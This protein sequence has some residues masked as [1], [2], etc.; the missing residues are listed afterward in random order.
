M[1][2]F[3]LAL[4]FFQLGHAY[5]Y[6]KGH[7]GNKLRWN[8]SR[9]SINLY[10]NPEDQNSSGVTVE[11]VQ[12]AI[13]E[14]VED[15]NKVSPIRLNPVYTA[16][17][18]ELGSGASFRFSSNP[19]YFGKG[20]LA[21][22][23]INYDSASGSI[24]SA[25]I[26]M[27]ESL[28]SGGSFTSDKANSSGPVAYIGDVITHEVGHLLGLNHSEV[29]DSSMIYSIFKGQHSIHMDDKSAI[30]DLYGTSGS[31]GIKGKVVRRGSSPV[32][33]AHVQA[34]NLNTNEVEM[35]VFTEEDGSFELKGLSP[36]QSYALF[37]SPMKSKENLLSRFSTVQT[38]YCGGS[39]FS[40][41]FFSRCGARHIGKAQAIY[42]TNSTMVDVGL[43][44]VK[45][46]TPAIPE[47]LVQKLDDTAP[48]T[49]IHTYFDEGK[50]HM[51]FTG[52]F[53][54]TEIKEG[55]NP[56]KL[57]L[58]YSGLDASSWGQLYL[59]L[60]VSTMK[61]GSG[62]G[63][64]LQSKRSDELGFSSYSPL[65]DPIT[66]KLI[67]DFEVIRP[68]SLTNSNNVFELN[69][70]PKE[71]SSSE[72]TEIFASTATLLND[73]AIYF[74]TATIVDSFGNQIE[75][76]DD[77]PYEDNLSCLDGDGG[78]GANAYEPL[79]N[80]TSTIGQEQ[81]ISCASVRDVGNSRKQGFMSF[82]LG[83]M[84]AIGFFVLCKR[85]NDFFV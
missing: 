15:W 42:I 69:I 55:S 21:I 28:Y 3:L 38:S 6:S 11:S 30:K 63:L 67:L 1:K 49:Q 13:D 32:F 61:L 20:V 29:H 53:T 5:L 60:H 73:R 10:V 72:A 36:N 19:A 47:Y 25:D 26:L 81:G 77:A 85:R 58:D 76:F 44:G 68:L 37:M 45:C 33:G 46:S 31:A 84:L 65:S 14:A 17:P 75:A 40:P 54:Q 9:T 12:D 50:P 52:Y 2:L 78:P 79:S 8:G 56:D 82:I 64:D 59:K 57:T 35:G 66:S 51:T 83:L 71:L 48:P 16:Y 4:I 41:S 23:S 7:S 80:I 24:M 62:I 70:Y 39:D 74:L 34:I 22:T 18:P 43:F 27:N